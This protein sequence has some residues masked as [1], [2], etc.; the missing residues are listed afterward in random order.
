MTLPL[1]CKEAFTQICIVRFAQHFGCLG[2]DSVGLT[3]VIRITLVNF[4]KFRQPT[5]K[6]G[7]TPSGISAISLCRVQT[8]ARFY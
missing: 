6:K 7:G 5:N 2:H 3:A 4:M 1:S 8:W